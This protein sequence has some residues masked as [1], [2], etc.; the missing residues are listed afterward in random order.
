MIYKE[1]IIKILFEVINKN[2]FFIKLE[3]TIIYA[4]YTIISKKM[5][6]YSTI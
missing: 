5:G 3:Q 4:E 1:K 2:I 6:I